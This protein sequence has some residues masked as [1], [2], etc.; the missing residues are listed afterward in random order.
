MTS[1][2]SRST[3]PPA[4][5]ATAF[6][7]S[8]A[9]ALIY[10]LMWFRLLGHI[11]GSTA[12]ATATLLAAYLFGLGLGAWIM[13]RLSDRIRNL[14]RVYV[15][16]EVAIGLFGIASRWLLERGAL[17]YEAAYDWTA[18]SPTA[19][20]LARFVISFLLVAIPTTL[21]GATFPL[22]VHLLKGR[23]GDVGRATGR[24]YAVNTAGAAA[25][26]LGL[27]MLLL[28][29]LGV[30]LSLAFAAASNLAA[31]AL[32]LAYARGNVGTRQTVR[33]VV[34]TGRTATATP[35]L[36]AFFLSSFVSL[37]LETIWARHLGI[38]FGAHTYTFAFVLFAYLMGLFLGGA[39]YARLAGRGFAPSSVLRAGMA[40]GAVSIAVTLPFLDEL[41]V[42][43]VEMML[44]V[45]VTHASFLFTSGLLILFLLLPPALGFGIV[46]PAVVDLLSRGGR[47]TGRSVGL[48]YLVNT[49]GTTLGALAAGFHLVPSLGTQRSLELNVALL[50]VALLLLPRPRVGPAWRYAWPAVLLLVLVLPRWDWRLANAGYPKD[51]VRFAERYRESGLDGVRKGFGLAYLG[52]GTQATVSV[53]DQDDG[54]RVLL[55]D[56]K[57]E[58]SNLDFDMISQRMLA[59]LP[60]LFHPDPK[61][62][63]VLGVGSGTTLG[64]LMRFPL[65]S[66]EVAEISPEVVHVAK[67]YFGDVSEDFTSDRRV[68][69]RIDDGRNYLH[70][71][72]PESYDLIISHPSNPWMAGVSILFTDEFFAEV[73]RKLRPGGVFGQWFHL[74]NMSPENIRILLRTFL[75][76]FPESAMFVIAGERFTGDLVA[77]GVKDSLR[78]RRLP[79]DPSLP[80]G[81]RRALDEIG[82]SDTALLTGFIAARGDLVAFAGDGPINTDDRPILE[83]QA[84]ADR[85][86]T[87]PERVLNALLVGASD[88]FLPID[89]PGPVGLDLSGGLPP[90]KETGRGAALFSAGSTSGEVRRWI[91]VGRRFEDEGGSTGLYRLHGRLDTPEEFRSLLSRLT[92]D[93]A[94]VSE[95]WGQVNGHRALWMRTAGA[96]PAVAIGWLCP[97]Q[98]RFFFV[99]SRPATDADR[100]GARYPCL[101]VDR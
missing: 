19:L 70:F 21:M 97:L 80:P 35:L 7:L 87:D 54:G 76:H 27:P 22:M 66:I 82:V 17:L 69:V 86:F 53:I 84:P 62:A 47:A 33:E 46:F 51:P 96:V 42:P 60:V 45:G 49:V 8:G 40:L 38:F 20:L 79:D 63:F 16:I 67:R 91:L 11:F 65:E 26:T 55:I 18:D 25:G 95:G 68:T 28:P 34:P 58:A 100:L 52:E 15:A 99:S 30:T 5:L 90:G 32:V 73:K 12:T 75:R 41:S 77:V 98:Q 89:D 57:P 78:L 1:S 85:F 94:S 101:H 50:A 44:R 48:A 4:P 72:E 29:R 3:W 83:L 36:V 88:V 23:G 71:Q 92:G 31:A 9:S 81:I 39:L 37:A 14:P 6:F 64:T 74:Y 93:P 2:P 43:Q 56:G 13:G 10:E 61:R 59:V 24:A